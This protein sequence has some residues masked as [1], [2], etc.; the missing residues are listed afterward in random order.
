VQGKY[1]FVDEP[2]KYVRMKLGLISRNRSWGDVTLGLIGEYLTGT[3][4]G[5]SIGRLQRA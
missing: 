1:S 5:V 4:G 3:A 2:E